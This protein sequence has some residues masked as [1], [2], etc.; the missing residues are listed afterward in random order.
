MSI[1]SEVGTSSETTIGVQCG[2]EA[3]PQ[4]NY[5]V[6]QDENEAGK[7][8]TVTNEGSQTHVFTTYRGLQTEDRS[9]S[10]FI[11]SPDDHLRILC[12]HIC[13]HPRFAEVVMVAILYMTA[14]LV[15]TD[16]DVELGSVWLFG[17]EV[18]VVFFMVEVLLRVIAYGFI[19]Y[20]F[21]LLNFLDF[22]V[23]VSTLLL[24]FTVDDDQGH[25][26]SIKV[27]RVFRLLQPLRSFHRFPI[28]QTLVDTLF[29]GIP[30]LANVLTV[31]VFVLLVFGIVGQQL[32]SG[33]LH[34]RCYELDENGQVGEEALPVRNCPAPN[35]QGF[36]DGYS[37][38]SPQVCADADSN[39]K[40]GTVS[41]DNIL[42]ASYTVFVS[43]T[44][45]GWV[46]IMYFLMDATGGISIIY[47]LAVILS[48]GFV[49]MHLALAV[50]YDAYTTCK[51]QV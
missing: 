8:T 36:T 23:T 31:G 30:Y 1:V 45:E 14:M 41:F 24:W 19:T 47:S 25:L 2:A 18:C 40:S 4:Y 3:H 11:F 38:P 44:F 42:I 20:I 48:G 12:R 33:L 26:S 13:E 15:I 46:D 21:N 7:H 39:P 43:T 6:L 16:M 51:A 17:D 37:C 49:V 27:L 34:Y 5:T 29:R 10:L 9:K 50:I 28:L 32:Y 35:F 22:L